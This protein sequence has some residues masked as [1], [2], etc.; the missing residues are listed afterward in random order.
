MCEVRAFSPHRVNNQVRLRPIALP[1]EHGGWSLLLEPVALG[2][3]LAPSPTGILISVAAVGL[4]LARHPYKLAVRD[5]QTGRRGR[6]ALLA[7]RF[8]LLYLLVALLA[9]SLAVKTGGIA[10][11]LPLTFAVPIAIAQLALDSVG[12]SRS[13]IA[14]LA[15]A[16]ATGSLATAVALSGGWPRATALA[17]WVIMAARSVPTILYLRARLRLMRQKPA[18]RSLPVIAHM[19]ALSAIVGLSVLALAPWLAGVAMLFL[20][21]RALLGLYSSGNETTP[22]RLGVW[23]LSYGLM[24]VVLTCVGY[25]FG[26]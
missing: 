17:L 1:V 14:E 16:A 19:A 4:F 2:L 22:Q 26:L 3:L 15:G 11:L 13:L 7:E 21:I 9:G 5:W 10:F 24:T 18:S 23:E 12:R 25:V 6:R 20:L 8:A